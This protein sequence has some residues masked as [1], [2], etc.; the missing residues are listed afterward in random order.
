MRP[1]DSGVYHTYEDLR[2]SKPLTAYFQLGQAGI[3][4]ASPGETTLAFTPAL[5]AGAHLLLG[6]EVHAWFGAPCPYT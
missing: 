4:R 3:Q 6:Q 1:V 2:A 5:A